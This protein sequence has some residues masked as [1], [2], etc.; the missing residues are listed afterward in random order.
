LPTFGWACREAAKSRPERQAVSKRIDR[1][2]SLVMAK[3][4]PGGLNGVTQKF[5]IQG[6]NKVLETSAKKDLAGD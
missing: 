5:V 6:K 4:E 1:G 2:G 3:R